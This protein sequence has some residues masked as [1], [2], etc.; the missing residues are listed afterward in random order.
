MMAKV[1]APHMTDAEGRYSTDI[2][3]SL[4]GGGGSY[5]VTYRPN[6]EWMQSAAYPVTIDPTGNYFNDLATGIGDVF[7]SSDNPS[8]HTTIRLKKAIRNII[9]TLKERICMQATATLPIS[10]LP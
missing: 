5:R 8:H 4:E 7:V 10:F 6:D 1:E 2:A 9:M 3:V